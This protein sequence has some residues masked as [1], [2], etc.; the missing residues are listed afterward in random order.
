MVAEATKATV[1]ARGDST[2]W[3]LLLRAVRSALDLRKA[4][5]GAV[6]L[7]LL[8][9]G[10]DL[11]GGVSP[12]SRAVLPRLADRAF[13]PVT[14]TS[15][16]E[17]YVVWDRIRIASWRLTEPVRTLGGPVISLVEPGRG[18][19]WM[20]R[21]LL[22]IV[23][24][25]VVWGILGGAIARM[26]VVDVSTSQGP[27]IAVSVR[28]ALRFAIPLIVTPLFPLVAIG[29]CALACAGI[30]LLYRLPAGVGPFLGG[31]LLV[32]PLSL[33]LVMVLLLIGLLAGWPLM[34]AAVAAE[35]ED[36]LDAL[37]RCFGY[38]NQRL[39]KFAGCVAIAWLIGI[40]ALIGVDLLARAVIHL[41]HWGL[42]ISAPAPSLTGLGETITAGGTSGQTAAVFPEFWRGAVEYL[43]HGWIYAYFWTASSYI[44]LVLRY[45]VD[46][47]PWGQVNDPA[48]Q[49][50]TMVP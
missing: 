8:H 15:G 12:G 6:G 20:L 49:A 43:V 47:T 14:N 11:L 40:P 1:L 9:G 18:A 3:V 28:F 2:A 26:A 10:W 33:G 16:T 38:L 13:N 41:A 24:A 35:A 31:L 30:G 32:I 37:S 25:I 34:H 50:R 36:I 45:D 7:L 22:A 27:G 42:C 46:G 4:V 17:E 21:A 19:A 29:F 48:A 39:G 44:Y 23:W 5:L